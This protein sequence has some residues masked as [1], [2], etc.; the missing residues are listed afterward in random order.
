MWVTEA[1]YVYM[2]DVAIVCRTCEIAVKFEEVGLNLK[3]CEILLHTIFQL[4][5]GDGHALIQLQVG[6]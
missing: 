1:L 6:K 5:Y 3:Q 4:Q 2:N